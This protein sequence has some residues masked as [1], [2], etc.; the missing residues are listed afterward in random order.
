MEE[1]IIVTPQQR[2]A[3]IN[4]GGKEYEMLLTTEAVMR[5]TEHF[6]GIDK[7]GEK[8]AN[9]K[10]LS[11]QVKDVLWLLT[12]LVNQGIRRSNLKRRLEGETF[13]A[14]KEFEEGDIGVLT[15]IGDL[16][17]LKNDLIGAMMLGL[18]KNIESDVPEGAANSKNAEA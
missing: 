12:L 7:V 17:R 13:V 6:G 5:I 2:T 10:D 4:L 15:D 14:V 11:E 3:K 9:S 8:L 1:N 16:V 18:T